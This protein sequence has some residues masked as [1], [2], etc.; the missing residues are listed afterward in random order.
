M[1]YSVFLHPDVEKY[2]DSLPKGERKRCYES[3]KRLSDDPYKTRSGCDIKKMRGKKPFYRLRLGNN[4]FLYVIKDDQV[5]VEEA[6][7]RRRGY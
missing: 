1:S 3:L 2:L 7:R 6:F 5:L 4:R